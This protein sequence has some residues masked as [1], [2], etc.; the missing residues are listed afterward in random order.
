MQFVISSIYT[1]LSLEHGQC[2]APTRLAT[3]HLAQVMFD[4]VPNSLLIGY[5]N[6]DTLHGISTMARDF[7]VMIK[8]HRYSLPLLGVVNPFLVTQSPSSTS[9]YSRLSSKERPSR[10]NM[11]RGQSIESSSKI[12]LSTSSLMILAPLL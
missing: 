8:A 3:P 10:G 2:V 6:E 11:D 7:R 9:S 5:A 1:P 12:S 4:L